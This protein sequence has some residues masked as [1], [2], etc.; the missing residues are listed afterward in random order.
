MLALA[1]AGLTVLRFTR[2]LWGVVGA[3][4]LLS[5]AFFTQ[6]SALLFV[7]AALVWLAV[8]DMKRALAFAIAIA[9]LCGGGFVLLSRLLGAW[10]NYYAWDV[11]ISD[12][13]APGL[14]LRYVSDQLLA[15]SA[16][17]RSPR[18][19]R[20]RCRCAWRGTARHGRA[21][22]ARVVGCSRPEREPAPR[23]CCRR[24]RW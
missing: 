21:L 13:L 16:C 1:L 23:P 9:L 24:S 4:V 15:S 17:G 12:A 11:P 20:S 8:E 2:G 22:G 10:F 6:E 19:S 14:V 18:C 7:S 5:T 3:A